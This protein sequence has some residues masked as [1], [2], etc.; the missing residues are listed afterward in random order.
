[1]AKRFPPVA[2]FART[3]VQ[4]LPER[5]THPH[6]EESEIVPQIAPSEL[7]IEVKGLSRSFGRIVA[8]DHIDLAIY[9]GEFLTVFGPNGAGKTTLIGILSSLIKP[10]S[11][12]INFNGRSIQDNSNH[13]RRSIGVIEHQP[14]LYDQL[15]ARENLRFFGKMYG[16]E[17]L[18]ERIDEVLGAINL[19]H[20]ANDLSGTFSRGMLQ[21]LS[22][23]RAMLHQPSIY[24]LDEPY[25][26]LDQHSGDKL[27]DMLAK[28]KAE[29][30][31]IL[32][33]TH[34]LERGF[35]L[36]NRNVIMVKGKVE[37]D[38]SSEGMTVDTVR[39]MYYQLIGEPGEPR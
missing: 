9:K 31:T 7:I 10:T 20:R 23:A 8:L 36:S 15:T 33:T 21:R 5:A 6:P 13:L 39:D 17:S 12:S 38:K 28:L 3:V 34:N 32:M 35:E 19:H 27:R 2:S 30:K 24:L 14:L 22:I 1:V 16:I 37:Y 25:S 26:G 4:G 18:E 11:G 29:S